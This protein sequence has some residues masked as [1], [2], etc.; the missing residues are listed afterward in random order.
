MLFPVTKFVKQQRVEFL[1]V[2]SESSLSL[3]ITH[4]K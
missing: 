3:Q 1:F 4:L 2:Q